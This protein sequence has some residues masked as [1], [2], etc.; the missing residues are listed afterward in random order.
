MSQ[1]TTQQ[2]K[3]AQRLATKFPLFVEQL[4]PELHRLTAHVAE[5]G[6][7]DM[8][9]EPPAFTVG[10]PVKVRGA[11]Y[12]LEQAQGTIREVK[13]SWNYYGKWKGWNYYITYP[14]DQ[15]VPDFHQALPEF[16]NSR[17]QPIC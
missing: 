5:H 4:A 17:I 10:Q 8:I 16:P 13:P 7:R 14:A 1:T 6:S 3:S 15:N 9:T 12:T 11:S 2:L